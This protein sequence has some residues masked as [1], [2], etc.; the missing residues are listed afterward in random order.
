MK[1]TALLLP[2]GGF[3]Q[4]TGGNWI[5]KVSEDGNTAYK[6]DYTVRKSKY[7]LL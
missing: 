1:D 2:K 4:Q 6:V 3:Y 5:F 7:G